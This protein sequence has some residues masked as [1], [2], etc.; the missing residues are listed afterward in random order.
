MAFDEGNDS[1]YE[2]S[3]SRWIVDQPTVFIAE[4]IVPAAE[5]D[6]YFNAFSFKSDQSL[7]K[8]VI[9]VGPRVMRLQHQIVDVQH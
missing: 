9:N 1:F 3:T 2:P 7:E 4:R 5:A 8:T 6:Q